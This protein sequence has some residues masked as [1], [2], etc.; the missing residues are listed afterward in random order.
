MRAF[1]AIVASFSLVCTA[2]DSPAYLSRTKFT[3]YAETFEKQYAGS[4]EADK[5]FVCWHGKFLPV[6]GSSVVYTVWTFFI[7]DFLTPL[8]RV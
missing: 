4:E 2:F 7:P 6:F 8:C 5:A 3:Q 1:A